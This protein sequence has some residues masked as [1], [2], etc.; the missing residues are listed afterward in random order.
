VTRYIS[1]FPEELYGE[2]GFYDK[3]VS[4]S[5][6]LEVSSAPEI[7]F[8]STVFPCERYLRT[9][10]RVEGPDFEFNKKISNILRLVQSNFMTSPASAAVCI[11]N[12]IVLHNVILQPTST[13]I[14][15]VYETY[16]Q[17]DRPWAR[18]PDLRGIDRESVPHYARFQGNAFY[19]GSVGSSNYGHW[20]VD[21]LSRLTA[22]RAFDGPTTVLMPGYG[23]PIDAVRS[24]AIRLLAPPEANLQIEFIDPN[25]PL[26]FD[27]LIYVTP[28]TYH[29]NVKSPLAMNFVRSF[30]QALSAH[31][32]GHTCKRLFVIRSADRFRKLLNISE[33]TRLLETLGFHIVDVEEMSFRQQAETFAGADTIVGVMG[34]AMT[35]TI[36][37]PAGTRAIYLAPNGW[38]ETFYWDLCCA[39]DHSYT[40]LYGDA[41]PA[42]VANGADFTIE[43]SKLKDMLNGGR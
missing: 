1:C 37:S 6:L 27:R 36:F 8:I 24:E 2:G 32:A 26:R 38:A 14:A 39:L 28:V 30:G 17:N 42:S 34:A 43:C 40:V 41:Q 22:L 31:Q 25:S 10:A 9:D 5:D 13:G 4:L 20:L 16:R 11:H 3:E 21:D 19:L 15:I 29:P 18:L 7:E 33:V 35:N 23:N 12:C